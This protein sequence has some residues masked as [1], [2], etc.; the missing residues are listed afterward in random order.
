MKDDFLNEIK[1]HGLALKTLHLQAKQKLPSSFQI[2]NQRIDDP[3]EIAN[4]F[5]KHCIGPTFQDM[6]YCI[7]IMLFDLK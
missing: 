5:N 6:T 3:T 4:S 7:E 1:K 2:D